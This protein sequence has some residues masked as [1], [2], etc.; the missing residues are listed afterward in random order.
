MSFKQLEALLDKSY[1]SH[2]IPHQNRVLAIW[3][4]LTASEDAQRCIFTELGTELEMSRIIFYLDK[5]KYSMRF[6]LDRIAKEAEGR[7]VVQVP[8]RVLEKYF[9][10]ATQLMFAGIDHALASQLCAALHSGSASAFE[11]DDAWRVEIDETRHDKAYGALEMIGAAKQTTVDFATLIFHWIRNPNEI[12]QVVNLIANS[13]TLQGGLLTYRYD[14]LLAE[15]LAQQLPA[16]PQLLPAQWGFS[17]GSESETTLLTNAL[18]LR[19]IYHIAAVH[20]GAGVNS[21]R[22]GGIS[23]ILLV[24]SGDQLVEDIRSMTSLSELK[25]RAFCKCLTWGFQTATPDPALQPI[26]LLSAGCFAIPCIHLLSSDQQRNLL[27][28]LARTD[29]ERFHSQSHLFERDMISSLRNCV[30]PDGILLQ[31]NLTVIIDGDEEEIDAAFLSER[32]HRVLICELRWM[33][34]PGDPREVQNRKKACLEK[35]EQLHRK[36]EHVSKRPDVLGS[37]VFG[38][39]SAAIEWVIDGIV[40]IAGFAGTRSPSSQFPIMP[41]RLF[42]LGLNQA[43]SLS[44]LVDW[45]LGLSWLPKEGRHFNVVEQ[46][47]ALA[48]G[49]SVKIPGLSIPDSAASFS[50]DAIEMLPKRGVC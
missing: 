38:L 16:Q 25:V 12:P 2:P 19:C 30:A 28:L 46:D 45:C 17:W 48:G 47:I 1:L 8:R 27:S 22:G 35:V 4:C 37:S 21:L 7:N 43:S 20:F 6:A 23:N 24:I 34:G 32:E 14:G 44:A 29:P 18:A 33:L 10:I 40:L 26:I 42:E 31:T 15:Q 50:K 41:V 39:K 5:Y 9:K 11:G 36:V 13:V 3:Y 49:M